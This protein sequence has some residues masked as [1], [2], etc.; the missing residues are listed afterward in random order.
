MVY[1]DYDVNEVWFRF[2]DAH[3]IIDVV[4]LVCLQTVG[5]LT[6]AAVIS[7]GMPVAVGMGGALL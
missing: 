3:C 7:R 5:W 1:R 6:D 4:V 2:S